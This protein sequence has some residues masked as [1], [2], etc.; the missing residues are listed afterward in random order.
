MTLIDRVTIWEPRWLV[1]VGE[2]DASP[3]AASSVSITSGL[4]QLNGVADVEYATPVL[5]SPAVGSYVKL[6]LADRRTLLKWPM[7]EGQ[8]A[9]PL[10]SSFPNTVKIRCVD[11]LRKL[12]DTWDADEDFTGLTDGDVVKAAL[13]ASGISYDPADIQ[14]A[15]VEFLELNGDANSRIVG[16][17]QTARSGIVQEVNGLLGMTLQSLGGTV[18]RYRFDLAPDAENIVATYTRGVD[19]QYLA[20]DRARGPLD[21]I[22]NSVKVTGAS[23]ACGAEGACTCTVVSKASNSLAVLGSAFRSEPSP[24]SSPLIQS[25]GF[26]DWLAEEWLRVHAREGDHLSVTALIEPQLHV[27]DVIGFRDAAL[28][29]RLTDPADEAPYTITRMTV[30]DNL[31]SLDLEGGPAGP[32][33]S[34]AGEVQKRC[35]KSTGG[36]GGLGSFTAPSGMPPS[37]WPR[38]FVTPEPWI[39][40]GGCTPLEFEWVI[41]NA[42]GTLVFDDGQVAITTKGAAHASEAEGGCQA[43]P[44]QDWTLTGRIV[45]APG[46]TVQV[47][48]GDTANGLDYFLTLSPDGLH[49]ESTNAADTDSTDWTG[50]ASV[51]FI[52]CYSAAGA[53]LGA[54]FTPAVGS[55]IA[56]S[57]TDI[58][59]TPPA[60]LRVGVR[61]TNDGTEGVTVQVQALC[62]RDDAV[63]CEAFVGE[64]GGPEDM[65]WAVV[66]GFEGSPWSFPGTGGSQAINTDVDDADAYDTLHS[67][68]GTSRVEWA[69]SVSFGTTDEAIVSFVL[70]DTELGGGTGNILGFQVFIGASPGVDVYSWNG[71]EETLALDLSGGGH[72]W[73]IDADPGGGGTFTLTI[74]GVAHVYGLGTQPSAMSLHLQH[75]AS[76]AMDLS[77][78][79]MTLTVGG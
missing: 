26:A 55:P 49:I 34:P 42:D 1:V 68:D 71:F 21:D 36:I 45:P 12:T 56:L 15:G 9:A 17:R 41:D 51:E 61:A 73:A 66:P 70:A 28:G 46:M 16:T 40:C 25:T 48:L 47:G 77:V 53:F 23:Y 6:W 65:D 60:H 67:F 14:D 37:T 54:Q 39:E 18:A 50:Q 58:A 30:R 3:L 69:G 11:V 22:G 79:L 72:T 52:L 29:V 63:G 62:L 75:G 31:M 20:L 38:I 57:C 59:G 24:I 2:E 13:T 8:V 10:A 43:L 7:F 78:T 33:G 4:S 27:G 19:V 74:D 32:T 64:V 76:V 35:N 5:A 44:A